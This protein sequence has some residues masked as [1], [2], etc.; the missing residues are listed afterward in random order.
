MLI[1]QK[2]TIPDGSTEAFN[3]DGPD[4][5]DPMLM[6]GQADTLS[7]AGPRTWLRPSRYRPTSR[8]RRR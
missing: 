1:V 3:F 4:D 8:R 2:Q 7:V 5:F 6:D